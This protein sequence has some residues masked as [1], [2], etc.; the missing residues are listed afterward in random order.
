MGVPIRV[1][2]DEDVGAD[3]DR[4]VVRARIQPVIAFSA[5]KS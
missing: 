3:D 5:S 1:K 4:S 2:N